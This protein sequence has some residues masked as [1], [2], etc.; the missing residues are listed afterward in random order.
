MPAVG[1]N[2]LILVTGGSGFLAIHIVQ[3]LLDRGHRVRATVRSDAK[4]EYL[5]KVFHKHTDKFEYVIAEDVEKEGVFDSAVKGVDGV[6]HTASPFHFDSENQ[7]LDKLVNPAVKGTKNV[8]NSIIKEKNI[9][10]VII[11]SSFAAILD[12]NAPGHAQGTK[13]YTEA[14]WNVSDPT[15]SGEV[16]NAQAPINAYRASKTLAEKAAWEFHEAHQ[17]T[18]DLATVNPPFILG[19][20]LHQ[21]ES[22]DKLNTSM[23]AV[24]SLM[25]GGKKESDLA[26]GAGC[27]VDVRDVAKTHIEALTQAVGGG[28]R[29]AP[30]VSGYTFQDVADVVHS[31]S[32]SIPEEWKKNTPVGEKGAG[33]KVKQ[34]ILDGSKVEKELHI[35]YHPLKQIIEDS[36]ESFLDYEKRGWKGVPSDDIIY[37][38]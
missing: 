15:E 10:R 29:W 21:C 2:S 7:A 3:Q 6:M 33:A 16:G 30:T 20:I 5:K 12:R 13:T 31:T 37:L 1:P 36:I 9:K 8:L 35:K 28:Q 22:P 38:P 4:G 24:W 14:D 23:K 34:N 18:W 17:P 26:N 11:T 32:H 19:P 25:H 27:V